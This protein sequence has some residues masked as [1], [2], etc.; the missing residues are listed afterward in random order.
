MNDEREKAVAG[1]AV[2]ALTELHGVLDGIRRIIDSTH[3]DT[4][5]GMEAIFAVASAGMASAE[6]HRN[7]FDRIGLGQGD[8]L[9]D[10]PGGG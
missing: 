2:A 6:G 7:R 3:M 4:D 5:G 1:Q 8:A 9:H 10:Q